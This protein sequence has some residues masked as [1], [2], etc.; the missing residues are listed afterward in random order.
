MLVLGA[1][2]FVG[3]AAAEAASRAGW[4]VRCAGGRRPARCA[5]PILV[6]LADTT[7]L[8]SACREAAVVVH[9]AGLAHVPGAAGRDADFEAVNVRGTAAVVQAAADEGVRRL[10]LVSSV[11]V[12]GDGVGPPGGF[13]E[14]A[15]C[16]PTSPYGRSKLAAEGVARDAAARAGLELVV[17]R[18]ATVYGPGDPGNLARLMRLIDRDRFLWVGTGENLKTLIHVDDVGRALVAAAA[19]GAPV[20]TY[21][22]SAPPVSMASVVTELAKALGHSV[23]DVRL[24]GGPCLAVAQLLRIFGRR[25]ASAAASLKKWMADDL[26]NG[27]RFEQDFGWRPAIS[28]AEGIGGEVAWFRAT[29]AGAPERVASERAPAA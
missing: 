22:L 6:D 12:Y 17:L 3:A 7:S 14:T 28:L 5:E 2:G 25:G 29:R 11:S 23:P 24:P 19:I 8:R 9:A 16:R 10:V 20:G 27:G 21:N 4:M 15:P 13:D 26:F 1:S 18:L